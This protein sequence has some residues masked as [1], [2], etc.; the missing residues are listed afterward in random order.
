MSAV[1]SPVLDL[2]EIAQEA[3][4]RAGVEFRSGYALRSA[5]RSM[6]LLFMSWANRGL[7]LWTIEGP[8]TVDLSPGVYQYDLPEDTVDLIEHNIRTWPSREGGG[9]DA[10]WDGDWPAESGWDG[11]WDYSGN[12]PSDLPLT[13]FTVS[14]Y[15]AIP[16]KLAQ[17]RPSIISIRRAI[18]P[19]F[20]LWQVPPRTPFYQVVYWRL[21]RIAPLQPGGTAVPEIPWRFINALTAGMAFYMS[22]KSTDPK[23]LQKVQLLK[24]EYEEQFQLASDEDRDRAAFQFV[25]FDY[26]YI[27][28]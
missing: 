10:E 14:N 25:P 7:N 19:Y 22:L 23:A 1:A 8:T 11:G 21:R 17:G 26:S 2:A 6:E 24:S 13:R 20:L 5:R 18:Q 4:E 12:K 16:N 9:W 27:R 3:A 15:A 28:G